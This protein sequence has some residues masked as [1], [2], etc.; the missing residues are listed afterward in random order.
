MNIF[1]NN[2]KYALDKGIIN[3]QQL[4]TLRGQALSGNYLDIYIYEIVNSKQ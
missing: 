2:L 3:K 1:L 4:K